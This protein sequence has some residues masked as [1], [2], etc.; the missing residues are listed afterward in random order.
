LNKGERDLFFLTRDG[1]GYRLA[2]DFFGKFSVSALRSN[3]NTT[4]IDRL[5]EDLIAGLQDTATDKVLTSIDLLGSVGGG[6]SSS[7]MRELF[8]HSQLLRQAAIEASLLHMS[9]TSLLDRVEPIFQGDQ[10]DP[11]LASLRYQIWYYI[12]ELKDPAATATLIKIS[13]TNSDF[14]RE[15]VIHALRENATPAAVPILISSLDD[16]V[17]LIRYD[18][19]LA[20]ATLEQR[21]E[22]APSLKTFRKGE[23]KYTGAWKAWWEA[24]H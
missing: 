10:R 7:V 15:A 6:R 23:G 17:E 19:V 2:D 13:K 16:R 1:S 5:R 4:G 11:R 8:P 3:S 18:S 20:L 14:L 21:P 12:S 24:Q 22:L 9:D